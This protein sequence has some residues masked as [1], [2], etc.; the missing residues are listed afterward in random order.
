MT[1]CL[2]LFSRQESGQTLLEYALV[3][4]LIALVVIISLALFGQNLLAL[5]LNVAQSV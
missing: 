4:L 2:L 5:L 3:L 1:K